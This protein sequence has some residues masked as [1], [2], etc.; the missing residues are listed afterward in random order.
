MLQRGW[1]GTEKARDCPVSSLLKLKVRLRVLV[2]E[3]NKQ[4]NKTSVWVILTTFTSFRLKTCFN[5]ISSKENKPVGA[6]S[7]HSPGKKR[8]VSLKPGCFCESLSCAKNKPNK[9]KKHTNGKPRLPDVA[10]RE[11]SERTE[12]KAYGRSQGNGS[13]WP[14]FG[15][16][17][18]L[19]T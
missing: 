9:Q 14:G 4:T 3:K 16:V 17:T 1:K 8:T 10:K 15:L 5:E 12:A 13:F 19:P 7:F 11:T 2:G 6:A 18:M